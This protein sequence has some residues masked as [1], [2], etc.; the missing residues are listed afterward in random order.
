MKRYPI[1]CLLLLIVF[2]SISFLG[3]SEENPGTVSIEILPILKFDVQDRN[4]EFTYDEFG[5]E[6]ND[7]FDKNRLIIEANVDW[8][9]SV[10]ATNEFLIAPGSVDEVEIG[11]IEIRKND[12]QTDGGVTLSVE[13][14]IHLT[15]A[16]QIVLEGN[17]SIPTSVIRLRWFF[18][19]INGLGNIRAG[20]YTVPVIYQITS[21]DFPV[22]SG[23]A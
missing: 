15:T 16:P 14:I 23:P 6:D 7:V 13:N 8:E 9:F 18:E 10:H 20:F 11:N 1:K 3:F 4:V 19:N 2:L 5:N 22:A 21:S 12:I 17:G